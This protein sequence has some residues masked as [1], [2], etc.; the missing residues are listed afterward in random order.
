M[1]AGRRAARAIGAYLQGGKKTWPITQPDADAFVPP[2]A[3]APAAAAPTTLQ[4]EK[5]P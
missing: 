3:S 4:S 5:Q 2:G 1:G